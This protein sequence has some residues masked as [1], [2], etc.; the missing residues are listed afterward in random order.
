MHHPT[1]GRRALL[2]TALAA[3]TA[4]ALLPAARAADFPSKA[5]SLIA[6][7]NPGGALDAVARLIAQRLGP[8]LGQ[9][10]VVDNRP[11]VGGTLGIA[12]AAKAPPDGHTLVVVAD[13]FLT[14]SPRLL[15]GSTPQGFKEL[16]PVIE[17]GSSPMVLVAHPSLK[18]ASLA[19][20]IA[21]ARANGATISY[22]SGGL[23]SPH[24]LY[25]ALLEQQ[26]GFRQNHV[27][28]KSGPHGFKDVLAGHADLTF[29]VM[30]TA[31]AH[32]KSGAL[33]PLGVTSARR[34][35]EHPGIPAIAETVP[36]YESEFW[37]AVFAPP[38]TPAAV[39]ERLNQDIAAVLAQPEVIQSMTSIGM[40]LPPD[41]R[42]AT[43][44][45]KLARED[46]KMARLLRSLDLRSG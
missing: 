28:Y 9:A 22:A 38:R 16:V 8:R 5:I 7:S 11:G 14:V 25:M 6:P 24:H 19:E 33:V 29:I 12:L 20:Y 36:G 15:K 35:P 39:V 26:L 43:L 2:G 37:F 41:T 46:E 44:A 3:G 27:P 31:E 18:V 10:V 32:I 21:K 45:A 1:Y 13:S 42:A 30:S 40:R 34:L 23:G 4:L 17:L